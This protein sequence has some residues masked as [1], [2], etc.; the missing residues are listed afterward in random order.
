VE[1]N[2]IGMTK[3]RRSDL[4]RLALFCC[5]LNDVT[6]RRGLR[7]LR[8]PCLAH[9]HGPPLVLFEHSIP[10]LVAAAMLTRVSTGTIQQTAAQSKKTVTQIIC[11]SKTVVSKVVYKVTS[12]KDKESTRGIGIHLFIFLSCSSCAR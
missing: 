9:R 2:V 6:N 1:S 7:F 11:Q 8:V 10:I 12:T 4:I 5:L 3:N